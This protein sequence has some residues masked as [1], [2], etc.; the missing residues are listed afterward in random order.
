MGLVGQDSG[1]N[2]DQAEEPEG[3]A[4]DDD[5]VMILATAA[6]DGNH[7]DLRE[8]RSD[9]R[10]EKP[11]RLI[12]RSEAE[13]ILFDLLEAILFQLGQMGR[14]HRLNLI[15]LRKM[16][17]RFLAM[18]QHGFHRGDLATFEIGQLLALHV[19]NALDITDQGD[20]SASDGR[21]RLGRIE[22]ALGLQVS[23][24]LLLA[25]VLGPVVADVTRD[26][27]DLIVAVL[28]A[29]HRD[30]VFFGRQG[31][32]GGKRKDDGSG[33]SV[34][35]RFVLRGGQGGRG[36]HRGNGVGFLRLALHLDQRLG[37][38]RKGGLIVGC[39]ETGD[40]GFE[41]V[42]ADIGGHCRLLSGLGDTYQTRRGSD[43]TVNAEI[44]GLGLLSCIDD[45][46]V[47]ARQPK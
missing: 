23:G 45:V 3:R 22:N 16:F 40:E 18:G 34:D 9:G 8:L 43:G 42:G 6:N 26:G 29:A 21:V 46:C 35:R 41:S 10:A 17:R 20:R 39:S 27:S 7:N 19:G 30:E 31:A 36:N 12:V 25:V 15:A 47:I 14:L 1:Q 11:S 5:A 33:G 13:Q 4:E 24:Q 28:G 2:G 38:G 44:A 37:R 32:S